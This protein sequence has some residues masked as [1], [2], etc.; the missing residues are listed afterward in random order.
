M[1]LIH[2]TI[3]FCAELYLVKYWNHVKIQKKLNSSMRMLLGT[4]W[5]ASCTDM[6]LLLNWLNVPNMRIW[7]CVRTLKRIMSTPSY[8]T[9]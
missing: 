2:S 7:C 5:E 6:M 3:E 8:L 4:G 9:L 1:S